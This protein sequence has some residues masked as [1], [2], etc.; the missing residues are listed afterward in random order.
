[1]LKYALITKNQKHGIEVANSGVFAWMPVSVLVETHYGH[2]ASVGDL[3][4]AC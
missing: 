4:R 3:W 1:M 2:V